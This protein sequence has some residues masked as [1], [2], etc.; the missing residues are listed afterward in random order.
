MGNAV[1]GTLPVNERGTVD[2][3]DLALG[4]QGTQKFNDP[5]VIWVSV[6]RD[7][8]CFVTD[9]KIRITCGEPRSS[10]HHTPRHWKRDHVEPCSILVLDPLQKLIVFSQG[11]VVLVLGVFL[12]GAH[13]SGGIDKSGDVVD[14]AIGVI[15]QN[16]MVEPDKMTNTQMISQ[17]PFDVVSPQVGIAIRVQKTLGSGHASPVSVDLNGASLENQSWLEN[18]ELE[19]GSYFS[20]HAVIVEVG[21]ILSAPGIEHPVVETDLI[22]PLFPGD[23][24]WAIVSDPYIHSRDLLNDHLPEVRASGT[25]LRGGVFLSTLIVYQ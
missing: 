16:S 11:R 21:I 14:M 4:K 7:E 3:Y 2:S 17:G 22:F 10:I 13:H 23:E 12:D 1:D 20:C 25:D 19:K 18:G 8:H 5:T 15:P 6:L 24:G 9:V